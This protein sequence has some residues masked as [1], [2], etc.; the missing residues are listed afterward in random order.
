MEDTLLVATKSKPIADG[1]KS[2]FKRNYKVSVKDDISKIIDLIDDRSKYVVIDAEIA[3]SSPIMYCYMLM[4]TLK[5]RK[6]RSS[7]IV[8]NIEDIKKLEKCSWN[9]A[10]PDSILMRDGRKNSID[11]MIKSVSRYLNPDLGRKIKFVE[12]NDKGKCFLVVFFNDKIYEL[13]R[14]CIDEGGK[15][16]ID[17]SCITIGKESDCF[18]IHYKSGEKHEI[19]WDYVLYHCEPEYEY[20]KG[21][22]DKSAIKERDG[23]IGERIK[24]I[25]S[26]KGITQEQLADLTGIKRSNISRLESGK[27]TVTLPT[28][29][30]IADALN[31]QVVQLI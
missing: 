11:S 7:F 26:E 5:N 25:R 3:G 17:I 10:G 21:K 30:R 19:P 22:E 15:D 4:N 31:I 13:D 29:E 1:F 18:V 27:H 23:K 16:K 14:A 9:I 8:R 24:R 6:I 20:Y 12:Y 2:G 28:L